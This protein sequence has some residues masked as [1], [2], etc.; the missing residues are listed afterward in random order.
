MTARTIS[1]GRFCLIATAGLCAYCLAAD[2]V[3]TTGTRTG[4]KQ[5]DAERTKPPVLEPSSRPEAIL[6]AEG[7][8]DPVR[9]QE[10]RRL[11]VFQRPT[12]EVEG[13]RRRVGGRSRRGGDPDSRSIRRCSI[14]R[15]VGFARAGGRQRA[16]P[17]QQRDF[18]DGPLRTASSRFLSGRHL[19]GWPGRSDLRPIS[20]FVQRLAPPAS[21]RRSMSPFGGRGSTPAASCSNRRGSRSSITAFSFK[22]TKKFSARPTG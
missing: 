5:H 4:W 16:G 9:R 22:T 11:A 3:H 2:E 6:R 13:G 1:V 10:S 12:G 20:P 18:F 19:R 7:R 17:R 15:R 21:G 8:G 14:A